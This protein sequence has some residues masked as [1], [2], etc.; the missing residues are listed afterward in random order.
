MNA[1][2]MNN[3]GV[4]EWVHWQA[5]NLSMESVPVKLQLKKL[6]TLSFILSFKKKKINHF[7]GF[8]KW[9]ENQGLFLNGSTKTGHV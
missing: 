5:T 6:V 2:S 1:L 3:T 4:D 9:E 7:I 8:A